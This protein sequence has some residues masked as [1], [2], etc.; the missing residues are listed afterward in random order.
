MITIEDTLN[1]D[2]VLLDLEAKTPAAAVD[3]VIAVLRNDDRVLEWKDFVT[4]LRNRPPCRV[5]ETADFAICVPHVRTEAVTAM[6]MS[7]ARLAEPMEFPD[8]S[9]PVRYIFCMAIPKALASDY[10]RIAGSL[11]R[12]FT[13][14]DTEDELREAST[15]EQF[16]QILENLE[17]RI[18]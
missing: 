2:H 4:E 11:M 13:D 10:L 12:I 9:R 18:G 14:M 17:R 1:P 8:C 6:I 3:A 16:V 5:S 15:P 7:A